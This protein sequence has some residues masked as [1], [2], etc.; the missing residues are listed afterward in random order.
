MSII[1]IILELFF[2]FREKIA[3]ILTMDELTLDSEISTFKFRAGSFA[4]KIIV[5]QP[6]QKM[7]GTHH[8]IFDKCF[9]N[10][11]TMFGS[12]IH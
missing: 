6:H 2:S 5:L 1:T 3:Q 10:S 7:V 11:K 12:V 8:E 9:G 4:Q